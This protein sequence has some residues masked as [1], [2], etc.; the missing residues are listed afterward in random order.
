MKG[1]KI[2][3]SIIHE[4]YDAGEHHR[5]LVPPMY[6]T[7]TF[8]FDS[9]ED[10]ERLFAGEQEG[11]IYS[12]LANPTT[13]IL[14]RKIAH[15]EG[16]EAGL[17]FASGMAAVSAVLLTLTKSNDHILCSQGIYGCT[18]GLLKLMEKKYGITHDFNMLVDEQEIIAAI[19]PETKV[20]YLETPINP[21]MHVIDLQLVSSL[22]KERGI[23]VVVDNTFLSPYLQQP[24]LH[25]CDVVVH[26]ATKYICGHGDVVAG[27][28]VG[29]QDFITEMARTTQKDVGGIL[30]PFDAWLLIRGLKTLHVRMD[31]HCENAQ[32]IAAKLN[33][34]PAIENVYYPGYQRREIVEK[35]MR[36]SGGIISFEIKGDKQSAQQILNRLHVIKLAVSLGD[37]ET[38]IQHPATMTHSS[39]PKEDREQMGITD[40]LIRLSVGLENWQDIWDDLAQA[41]G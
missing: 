23:T 31:R 1:K 11:Y 16:G 34:H 29:K 32:K 37:A 36:N 15:L 20:I 26:S 12:R 17:A 14:E 24:I 9:A 28:V 25:G 13:Q 30:S 33:E 5:S 2:E 8:V 40:T 4:G 10:G 7:S 27:L 21:T 38:L 41:L 18:F 19:R 35:Q 6:Q 22:A 39:I 3:T